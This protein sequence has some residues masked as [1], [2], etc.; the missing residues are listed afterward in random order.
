VLRTLRGLGLDKGES[1]EVCSRPA[2]AMILYVPLGARE[3][4]WWSG[5]MGT[6]YSLQ[7]THNVRR[8]RHATSLA[9]MTR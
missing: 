1:D 3:P 5:R 9:G 2:P 7:S 6:L 4:R 8:C